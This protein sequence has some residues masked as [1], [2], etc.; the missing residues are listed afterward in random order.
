MISSNAPLWIGFPFGDV[1]DPPVSLV[2]AL[3]CCVVTLAL[4]GAS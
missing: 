1:D 2:T 3:V 4:W